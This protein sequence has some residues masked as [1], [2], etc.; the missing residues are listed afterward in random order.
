MSE[1]KVRVFRALLGAWNSGDMEAVGDLYAPDATLRAPE[2]WPEQGP[3]VGVEAI[4]RQWE[5]LREPWD[6][7]TL[8][9]IADFIDTGDR[10]VM[11]FV[12]QGRGRGPDLNLEFTGVVTVR[13]GKIVY[14][15]FFWDHAE[16]LETVGLSE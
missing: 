9:P 15:E 3:F 13:K 10:V 1:E 5:R 7:D 8:E 14:H 6:M 2:G 4:M 12:W 16:A 11:R